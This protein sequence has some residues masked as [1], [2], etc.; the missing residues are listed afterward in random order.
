MAH[1]ASPP[2]VPE[3][4]IGTL[5]AIVLTGV[6]G[7]ALG[8]SWPATDVTGRSQVNSEIEDWHGNVR[9]STWSE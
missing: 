7:F 6:L 3:A 4:R 8:Q 2:Q 9:R 5:V 1:T